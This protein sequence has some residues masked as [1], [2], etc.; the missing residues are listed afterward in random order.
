MPKYLWVML[1]MLASALGGVAGTALA[2]TT[3]YQ[4]GER[5]P[6]ILANLIGY[7]G[8]FAAIVG[9]LISLG[10]GRASGWR[11]TLAGPLVLSAGVG[12]AFVASPSGATL[13]VNPGSLLVLMGVWPFALLGGL[14]A[15]AVVWSGLW[16]FGVR[17]V[18]EVVQQ[19][20]SPG[21]GRLP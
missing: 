5:S 20:D 1:G 10:R 2:F 9:G 11:D 13:A 19:V 21:E 8:T 12:L 7:G 14:V 18:D 6:A 4:S 17:D 15:L 16:C 3:V